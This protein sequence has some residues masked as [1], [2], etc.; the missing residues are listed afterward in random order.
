M[1]T[2]SNELRTLLL[3]S[4]SVSITDEGIPLF[5]KDLCSN[6]GRKQA[7]HYDRVAQEYL[8]N[9]TYPHTQ[10]YM[11]YLDDSLR[12]VVRTRKLG[13]TA[14]VCCGHG[15]A[16]KL[17][18]NQIDYGVGVDVS[19]AMLKSAAKILPP[20]KFA[21]I[22]ADA[23]MLPIK[24]NTLDTVLMF[25]GIHHV[26]DR[27][28]LFAEVSRVLIPGGRFIFREPVSD[29]FLWKLLRD[30]VYRVSPSL[31]H[32]TERPLRYDETA[33]FL[34]QAGLR[35][36]FWR[37]YGFLGFCIFMNSDILV[38]NRLF[39]F[40]PGISGLVTLVA[41]MDEWIIRTISPKTLGLQVIGVAT[42]R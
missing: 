19:L 16:L 4:S 7:Q 15:E 11:T 6:D 39:R 5:A 36:E 20:S 17:L 29:F 40:I 32:E 1:N 24:D 34:E 22:Q 10:A 41:R 33:P 13:V 26:R 28:K 27:R 35:L 14:E 18:E 37:T 21:F 25:G 38:F 23:T 30:V 12:S 8:T 3:G 42:K 9:L 2:I 31:D